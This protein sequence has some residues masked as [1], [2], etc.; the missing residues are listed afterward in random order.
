MA[1]TA[2]GEGCETQLC[3]NCKKEIPAANFT[4]HELHCSRNIGICPVCKES[5][6]KS[7][8][9]NHQEQEHTQ[10]FC[11]CGMRM[12][13]GRLEE[14]RASECRLRTVACQHCDIQLAFSKLQDHEDYCGARTERC[15]RCN[16][17][18]L[19]R[20]LKTHPGDCAEKAEEAE[21]A[22]RVAERKPRLNSE[23]DLGNTQAIRNFLR[24]EGSAGP[25]LKRDPFPESRLYN[26]LSDDRWPRDFG[27]RNVA[28]SWP[29]RSRA[30]L[31]TTATPSPATGDLH[32]HLDYLLALS[33][34]QE[35]PSHKNRAAEAQR[36]L[37]KSI[38][39]QEA[40]PSEDWVDA[41]GSG[42]SSRDA[43]AAPDP[44]SKP[45]NETRLPCEF[46]EELYP[47]EDLI[48]HQTGC[49]PSS[50]FASFSKSSTSA[51]RSERL[52]DL[53]EQL[54]SRQP[55][56]G[57]EENLFGVEAPGSLLLPCE[58]CGV[59]LEEEIVFH[60]Q[61]QC[62]LRPPTAPS[63]GKSPPQQG[64]PRP[65]ENPEKAESPE[66]PRRRLRHQGE[67][68]PQYLEEFGRQKPL[69]AARGS[70]GPSWHTPL[71]SP[72]SD[73]KME[74][75]VGPSVARKAKNPGPRIPVPAV[76]RS[77][78]TSYRPSF[79]GTAPTRPG[80]RTERGPSPTRLARYNTSKVKPWPAEP[81]VPGDE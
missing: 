19:V 56:S 54:Q 49:N 24:P 8:M 30:F 39:P 52:R 15:P 73:K 28:P 14:H 23:V 35:N 75:A 22:A 42:L 46:C 6:P 40:R 29:D 20:E 31:E 57:R 51:P 34:Q 33:L 41:R 68:S 45:Q 65:A 70:S 38:C 21:E 16:R 69:Q 17:N 4:T 37:W 62:D 11:K 59:Q 25:L 12:D 79:P 32:C 53:W 80:L 58:F 66:L 1:A 47:E 50:A 78:Q 81:D 60:H 9:S 77:S 26:C 3:S 44:P 71:T 10:V 55:L 2:E 61:E 7:E 63:R 5:F 13:K 76:R 48:L 43:L 67:I 27:R 18:V 74:N 72:S 64:S 36:E